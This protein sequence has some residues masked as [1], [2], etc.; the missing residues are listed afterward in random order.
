MQSFSL[1]TR[2]RTTPQAFWAGN[3]LEAVNAELSPLVKMTAPEAWRFRTIMT[4]PAGE[5]CFNSI[6]LL[7]GV[8]P[9]DVHSF[10]LERVDPEHGILE[11]SHSWLNR[12][13]QHERTTKPADGQCLVTDTLTVE[14]R[15]GFLSTLL[16][17]I[18]RALFRHRHRR[19]LALYGGNGSDPQT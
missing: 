18:N 1:T 11:R 3:T 10:Q 5:H 19:L 12:L 16:M 8:L 15:I 2:I 14:T 6:I 4:W 7:F 17:P 13:W 9:V